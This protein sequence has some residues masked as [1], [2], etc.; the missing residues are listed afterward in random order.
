MSGGEPNTALLLP[1]D[2]VVFLDETGHETF[3]D[4]RFPVF[5]FGG[6]VVAADRLDSDVRFPWRKLRR[7][8]LGSDERPLHASGLDRRQRAQYAPEI[9]KFFLNGRFARIGVSCSNQSVLPTSHSALQCT[10][11]SLK[12]R[13]VHI[14]KFTNARRLVVIF[15]ATHRIAKGIQ[16]GFGEFKL[17]EGDSSIPV[18]MAF[19]P[20]AA[21]EP[22]LEAADFVAHAIG[23]H[24]HPKRRAQSSYGRDFKSIFHDRDQREVSYIHIEKVNLSDQ[25]D[26]NSLVNK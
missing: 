21:N 7:T 4:H 14:F 24:A 10:L 2:L 1:G 5:G 18:E 13:I 22:G 26:P 8:I 17:S 11:A 12:Q 25:I 19:M 20:K 3:D 9:G 15:E 16:E 6:I 23:H